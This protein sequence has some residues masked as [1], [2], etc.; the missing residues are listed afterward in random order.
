M[1]TLRDHRQGTLVTIA[2]CAFALLFNVFATKR[3]P[4]FEGAILFFHIAG[5]LAI[6]IPLWVL[7][8]KAPSSEVWRHFENSGGWSSVGAAVIVGQ[9]GAAGAFIGADSAAHMAEE[10]RNASLTVPRMMVGTVALNGLLGFATILTF[11]YS[12]QDV[13]GQVVNSTAV[14]PFIDVFATAVGSDAGAIGMT[15]PMIILSISMCVNA[16]AA[17]SRQAWSFSRDDGLPFRRLF[18]KI[19]VVNGTP[20]P[21]NAMVAS[22][23]IA[24][25][26]ALL[27]LGGTAAFN[28]I[29]GLVTGAVGLTYALSIGCL[30]WRRLFGAPLP[31]ARW[32]LGRYGVWINGF[33]LLYEIFTVTISFFPLFAD[34]TAQSMNWAVAMFG[35]A[36]ILCS[37]N[38]LVNGRKY[39]RGPVVYLAER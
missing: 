31:Y 38:Y 23:A 34:V 32:S 24:V 11:L 7:A 2:V 5:F 16:V 27:N 22:L 1:R 9:L 28:S 33:A 36:A 19:S 39:Y 4:L 12:I 25:V 3:L 29:M 13:Q 8:P 37:A 30:L 15:V 18:R 10:V 6:N 14:Y 35:G 20:L 17:A 21:V 26:L